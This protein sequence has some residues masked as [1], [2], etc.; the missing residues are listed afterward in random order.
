MP[1]TQSLPPADSPFSGGRLAGLDAVRG[2]AML[3]G[4]LLHSAVA[5]M[6]T[7]MPH[8]LWPVAGEETS[9]VCDVIFWGLHAIRLPTFFFLSGFLA[10]YI[11]QSRGP[12]KFLKHRILRLVIPYAV[13]QITI[14]PLT[15]AVWVLGWL[16]TGRCSIE[17]IITPFVPFESEIQANYF[18]PGHLW[19]LSDLIV[20]NFAFWIIRQEL[21][22]D[23]PTSRLILNWLSYP[24]LTPALLAMPVA[25]LL[26]G[27]TA[28]VIEFNNSF[29]PDAP[30]LLYYSIFFSVGVGVFRRRE[31]F[32]R[33]ARRPVIHLACAMTFVIGM[34]LFVEAEA[35]GTGGIWS[36]LCFSWCV[37]LAAWYFIFG[38]MGLA[39]TRG[40]GDNPRFRYLADSA[41]WMYLVHLPIVGL[42]QIALRQVA[43]RPEAKMLLTFGVSILVGLGSYQVFVRHT[44]IGLCLHG[45][46]PR[47]VE[48]T[49]SPSLAA[50]NN[51]VS[52]PMSRERSAA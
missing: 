6:R 25:Q 21:P 5:Y 30:R 9:T 15:F 23:R 7:P 18:N 45:H 36:R 44:V 47:P 32:C 2:V 20:M 39:I 31:K 13:G 26:W 17:Q 11:F 35:T 34:L 24:I 19:F 49:S 12:E 37:A 40:P 29:L 27:K 33:A 51:E 14:L 50:L 16:V 48:L 28:P 46:R 22:S 1:E 4:I 52:E 42:A 8:L 3:S 43:M 41:Y 10:E 38:V